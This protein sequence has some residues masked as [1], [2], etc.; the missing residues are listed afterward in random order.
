MLDRSVAWVDHTCVLFAMH[1][2]DFDF[3]WVSVIT[4]DSRDIRTATISIRIGKSIIEQ[5][6]LE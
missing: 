4:I 6:F 5:I 3:A 2:S 1:T